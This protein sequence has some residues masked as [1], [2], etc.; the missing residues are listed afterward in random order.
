VA[1]AAGI[2]LSANDCVTVIFM[3]LFF[4]RQ[5]MMMISATRRE[6]LGEPDSPMIHR[7]LRALVYFNCLL[8]VCFHEL[9]FLI[10]RDDFLCNIHGDQEIPIISLPPKNRTID[11]LSEEDAYALTRFQKHQLCLLMVHL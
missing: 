11:E 3:I 7:L 1:L 6:F 5:L 9:D 2:Q 10:E 8:T 4:T